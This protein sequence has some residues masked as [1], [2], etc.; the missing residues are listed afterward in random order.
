MQR[1]TAQRRA[2]RGVFSQ[3]DRPLTPQ[4][5]LERAQ[6]TVPQIGL[7]TVYR[8][9]KSMTEAETVMIV[10]VPGEPQRYEL[11]GK[12]HHHHF[13]CRACGRM[14]EMDGCPGDLERLVP[15]GFVMEDH[16]VFIYGRC[17]DCQQ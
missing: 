9:L 2:I 13:S 8:T 5:L 10:D 6:D 15:K 3:E 7:A 12:D 4:E 17:V 1:D 16:E 11:A 14:F